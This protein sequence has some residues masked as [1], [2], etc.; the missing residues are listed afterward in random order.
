M[1]FASNNTDDG[2]FTGNWK[3]TVAFVFV[4]AVAK[5]TT[6]QTATAT[7]LMPRSR[8][9]RH[10]Q[11]TELKLPAEAALPSAYFAAPSKAAWSI[12]CST[13][14][15]TGLRLS[16]P[17]GSSSAANDDADDDDDASSKVCML[18]EASTPSGHITEDIDSQF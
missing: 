11:I 18:K 1:L 5:V 4:V 3:A 2:C 6:I 15:R 14:T 9:S 17:L 8:F 12:A 10:F 16:L 13:R 7:G